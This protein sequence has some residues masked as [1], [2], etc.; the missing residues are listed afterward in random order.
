[1]DMA[2]RYHNIQMKK[3]QFEILHPLNFLIR[4]YWGISDNRNDA[5][6]N[7]YNHHQFFW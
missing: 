7:F 4:C 5:F 2:F 6:V 3:I 1:M